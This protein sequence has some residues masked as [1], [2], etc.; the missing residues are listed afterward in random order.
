MR[1]DSVCGWPALSSQPLSLNPA[2]V[3]TSVS[4]S[5]LPTEYPMYVGFGSFGRSRPSVNTVRCGLFGD[6]CRITINAE[7]WTMRVRLKNWW[8]GR[9]TGIHLASGLSFLDSRTRWRNSFSAHGCTSFVSRSCAMLKRYIGPAPDQM[10][11]RSGLPSAVFGAG[12][13]RF[14]LPSGSRGT[15]GVG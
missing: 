7:V 14:A 11:E 2:V 1:S 6:S 3:T 12:A 13:A 9:L 5:H 10:P 8:Y 15:P 4:P